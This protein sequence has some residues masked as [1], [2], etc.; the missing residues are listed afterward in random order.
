MITSKQNA[1][2]KEIRSLSDKKYRDRLGKYIAEGIK[3]VNEA[4]ETKQNV[5][6]IVA[7]TSALPRL[8]VGNVRVEEVSDDVFAY[9]SEEVNPQ[10]ALAVINKPKF[11]PTSPKGSCVFLDGV[12][13][14]SNVGAII[15]T[16]VASGYK[17]V[18]LADCADPFNG[19][20]VRASMSGVFRANLHIGNRQTLSELID[21]PVI[22]ADMGGE[23]V[24]ITQIQG[25]FCLVIGNEANG[26]SEFMRAKA[27][28]TVKIPMQNEMESL[29]ASVS[30]G[31]LMYSLKKNNT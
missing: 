19:K 11:N 6:C 16:A 2:V 29:N 25:E 24:F 12:S 1:L 7:T 23:D 8:N 22:I 21:L 20:S 26:V 18:Y 27:T 4:V 3:S 17:D 14:P 13:D 5:F 10:G 30:A 9:I 15:R 31:I 28:R